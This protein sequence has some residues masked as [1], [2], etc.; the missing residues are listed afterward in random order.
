MNR[1]TPPEGRSYY[2]GPYKGDKMIVEVGSEEKAATVS[3]A[4]YGY[5]HVTADDGTRISRPYHVA[6]KNWRWA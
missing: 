4:G 6:D 1:P 3:E 2:I 5:F